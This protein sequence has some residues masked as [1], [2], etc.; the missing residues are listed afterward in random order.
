MKKELL[1]IENGMVLQN[2]HAILYSVFIRVF[3]GDIVGITSDRS[4]VIEYLLKCLCGQL[5]FD[6]GFLY[7]EGRMI[8]NSGKT[9]AFKSNYTLINDHSSFIKTLTLAENV[10]ALQETTPFFFKKKNSEF[11]LRKMMDAFHIKLSV[12][13]P[14][15]KLNV[16]Q[17]IQIEMLKAKIH[18]KRI[19]M[20]D[21]RNLYL[22]VPEKK[23]LYQF[24]K[25]LGDSG[26]CA[27]V[28]FA[29][30]PNR[31]TDLADKMVFMSD[32]KVL[33]E[34]DKS[35]NRYLEIEKDFS[36]NLDSL[37]KKYTHGGVKEVLRFSDVF[38]GSFE[39]LNFA[40]HAGEVVTISSDQWSTV[41]EIE[42]ILKGE[43]RPY[44]GEIYINQR[45]YKPMKKNRMLQRYSMVVIEQPAKSQ[46]LSNLSFYDNLCISRGLR[47]RGF[48][49]DKSIKNSI[50]KYCGKHMGEDL[51]HKKVSELTMIE[52]QKLLY[53]RWL[54]Y[55]PEIVVCVE[56]FKSVDVYL[57][58]NAVEMIME[59]SRK[60]IAVIVLTQGLPQK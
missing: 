32:G 9:G 17:R 1:R 41:K 30:Q 13:T 42:M 11:E 21:M 34:T 55:S 43:L 22:S 15:K 58:K 46:L 37:N 4:Y 35:E 25:L 14:V 52:A 20:I 54:L 44:K 48:W 24:L 5:D 39:G 60:G 6:S 27:V 49:Y 29:N 40:V 57:E 16:I 59:M 31:I 38:A 18:G 50:R 36:L 53:L 51:I 56:P 8:S 23:E 26:D 2:K 12:D 47:M 3:C 33:I 28:I 45:K 7:Y 10:F 19:F